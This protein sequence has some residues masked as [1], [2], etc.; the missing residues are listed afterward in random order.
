MRVRSRG[1]VREGTFARERSRGNVREGTFAWE[2]S[3]GNVREGT[4]AR[5]RSRGNVREGTFARGDLQ[6]HRINQSVARP[7][8]VY[9]LVPRPSMRAWLVYAWREGLRTRLLEDAC[10]MSNRACMQRAVLTFCPRCQARQGA[11]VTSILGLGE[12]A[13]GLWLSLMDGNHGGLQDKTVQSA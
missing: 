9:V 5:E 11:Y 8:Y 7:Y 12:G 13:K 6:G 10:C 1:N 4:F 2:R 3:R